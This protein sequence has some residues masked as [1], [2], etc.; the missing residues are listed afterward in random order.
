MHNHLEGIFLRLK[1]RSVYLLRYLSALIFMTSTMYIHS[2]STYT[3]VQNCVVGRTVDIHDYPIL[4]NVLMLDFLL[5]T[6]LESNDG[7]YFA[8]VSN[9]KIIIILNCLGKKLISGR[10]IG[11][12]DYRTNI[13]ILLNKKEH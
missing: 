4:W 12:S 11:K 9:E 3:E 13:S 7:A 5:I 10:K 6:L 1:N 8:V 2:T